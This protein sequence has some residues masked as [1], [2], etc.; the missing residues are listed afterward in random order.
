MAMSSEWM[1]FGIILLVALFL[2]IA[3]LI[4]QTYNNSIVNMND[5]WTDIDYKTAVILTLF[6]W[7]IGMILFGTSFGAVFA[8]RWVL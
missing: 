6:L 7:F 8:Q 1:F 4:Q 3:Y 5:H 2:L